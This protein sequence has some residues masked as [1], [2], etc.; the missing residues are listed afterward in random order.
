M[1]VTIR[2]FIYG[3]MF[4]VK[5]DFFSRL[6]YF[7]LAKSA[8]IFG[9]GNSNFN[10]WQ[11]DTG[12]HIAPLTDETNK[13]EYC[14]TGTVTVLNATASAN[15]A[16]ITNANNQLSENVPDAVSE[17]LASGNTC[18]YCLDKCPEKQ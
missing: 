3:K 6:L 11:T 7:D 13:A 15:N 17:T 16:T 14:L 18:R 9:S 4:H 12:V 10:K 5:N 2:L 8:V 1:K